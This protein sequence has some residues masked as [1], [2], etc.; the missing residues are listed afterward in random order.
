MYEV[1]NLNNNALR[2]KNSIRNDNAIVISHMNKDKPTFPVTC[3]DMFPVHPASY[4]IRY[5]FNKIQIKLHSLS[6][7]IISF[8]Y[9]FIFFI[10]FFQEY[11]LNIKQQ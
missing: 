6:K 3:F 2:G 4:W 9:C 8:F 5:V 1:S 11:I 10:T 7:F